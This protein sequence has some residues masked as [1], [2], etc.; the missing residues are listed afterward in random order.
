MSPKELRELRE[1]ISKQSD[2]DLLKIVN[3][4]FKDYRK[5]TVG[6]A[7]AELEKRDLTHRI[8]IGPTSLATLPLHRCA[9]L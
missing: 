1:R 4:D 2:E 5:E 8:K 9:I 7:R 3:V 6:F